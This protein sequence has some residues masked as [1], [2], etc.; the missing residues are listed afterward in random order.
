MGFGVWSLVFGMLFSKVIQTVQYW[1]YQR[2]WIWLKPQP[3]DRPGHIWHGALWRA[4]DDQWI[5]D[6]LSKLH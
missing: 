1:I 2:P 3:W 4:D 6:L 5:Y